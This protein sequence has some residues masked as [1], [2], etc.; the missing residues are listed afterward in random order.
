M[1]R[2]SSWRASAGLG[3]SFEGIFAAHHWH[4]AVLQ[5][6]LKVKLGRHD[7]DDQAPMASGVKRQANKGVAA[8]KATR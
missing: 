4:V 8:P 3:C 7:G 1:I 2:Q 6:S 5:S